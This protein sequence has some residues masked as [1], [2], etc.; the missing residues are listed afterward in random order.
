MP[1]ACAWDADF[2]GNKGAPI[3]S[4]RGFDHMDDC[5]S[6]CRDRG[7]HSHGLSNP[8]E[9]KTGCPRYVETPM[10]NVVIHVAFPR[11]RLAPGVLMRSDKL[12]FCKIDRSRV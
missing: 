10:G 4:R 2:V 7:T 5:I 6:P 12:T 1:D 9:G 3:D 11:M 8:G